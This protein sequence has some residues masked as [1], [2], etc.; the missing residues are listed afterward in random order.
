[1][2]SLKPTSSTRSRL[3]LASLIWSGAGAGLLVAGLRWLVGVHGNWIWLGLVAA[4]LVGAAKGFL[5]L[6]RR[7]DANAR[8]IVDAGEARC[9]GGAF[10]WGSWLLTLAMIGAGYSLRHSPLPRPWLGLVYVAAGVGLLG[11]S[12]V[13]W[14]HWRA[15]RPPSSQ[16]ST[17]RP[18]AKR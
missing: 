2:Y 13:S 5:V 6:A 11:A 17:Q 4:L 3:L 14:S 15:L 8:R 16:G 7:A 1:L 9:L 12:V 10:S 18:S